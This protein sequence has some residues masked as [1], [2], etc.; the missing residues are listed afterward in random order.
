[1]FQTLGGKMGF[2]FSQGFIDFAL[3]S[4]LGTKSWLVLAFGPLFFALYYVIFYFGVKALNLKTPGR[5]DEVEGE[6]ST[7]AVT[8]TGGAAEMSRELVRAFGGRSNIDVLDACITRLRITVKDMSRVSKARLKALGASGVLE[9][10]NSAQAIFGPRS[11]NLKTDMIEYLKTAGPEADEA[12][13]MASVE[14]V[15]AVPVVGSANG[16]APDI[17]PDAPAKVKGIISALGGSGNIRK[18]DSVA[19]TRLRVE[20][21][22]SAAV[23]EAALKASGVQAV[24]RLP[25]GKLH[26]IIG[27]GADQYA[28]EMKGQVARV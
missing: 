20:V 26:L 4:T 7:E 8:L 11:E 13:T 22:D 2:T 17:D 28:N 15:A 24:L 5:E 6:E 23:D 25:G 19:L 27:L 3:F 9:V 10:G 21:A 14:P 16:G 1:L 18:V 12:Y